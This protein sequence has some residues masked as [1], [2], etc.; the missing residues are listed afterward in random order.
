MK[1]TTLFLILLFQCTLSIANDGISSGGGS[2][3]KS[4][5]AFFDDF[6]WFNTKENIKACLEV[7][8]DYGLSSE[9]LAT[10]ARNTFAQWKSYLIQRGLNQHNQY[11]A[12]E[13]AISFHCQGDES[14]SLYFGVSNP[15][16][17]N[18]KARYHSPA[19]MA[20][21]TEQKGASVKG[22]V[23]IDRIRAKYTNQFTVKEKNIVYGLL[24][25]EVGHVFGN[26]H[27]SGTIMDDGI[28]DTLLSPFSNEDISKR[29]HSI[30]QSRELISCLHCRSS[31]FEDGVDRAAAI[32]AFHQLTGKIPDSAFKSQLLVSSKLEI[33]QCSISDSKG[34]CVLPENPLTLE[35]SDHS[36]SRKFSVRIQDVSEA[37]ANWELG[38][39]FS[40]NVYKETSVATYSSMASPSME[41]LGVIQD[42]QGKDHLVKIFTNG[43]VYLSVNVILEREGKYKSAQILSSSNV[44][45][46]GDRDKEKK[47][48][49]ECTMES[50]DPFIQ[51]SILDGIAQIRETSVLA[52][53]QIE[54]GAVQK[55]LGNPYYEYEVKVKDVDGRQ[56]LLQT[57]EWNRDTKTPGKLVG[58]IFISQV[59]EEPG[60]G[61]FPTMCSGGY[62]VPATMFSSDNTHYI[63]RLVD[64]NGQFVDKGKDSDVFDRSLWPVNVEIFPDQS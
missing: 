34:Y 21:V 13:L 55:F 7:S 50:M 1:A 8:D 14:L 59:K 43:K 40:T 15:V 16:V 35:L 63:T 57:F 41:I 49:K 12:S 4:G 30:D 58:G 62:L 19:G 46:Y 9:E 54:R 22:F 45:G 44:F 26:Q 39:V 29:S 31:Y 10:Y 51:S 11:L 61:D 20:E 42:F 2:D 28:A 18:A 36:I 52:S 60:S 3:R 27:T 37:P 23:W 47:L 24:L 48:V 17:E 25:H 5:K 64:E 53:S 32:E 56:Y 6:A 38:K 33:D